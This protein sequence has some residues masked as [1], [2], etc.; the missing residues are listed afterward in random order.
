MKTKLFFFALLT[1]TLASCSGGG[2]G[3]GEPDDPGEQPPVNPTDKYCT[4][5]MPDVWVFNKDAS[6]TGFTLQTNLEA[7]DFN[8]TCSEAWCT[9]QVQPTAMENT[10]RLVV[11]ATEYDVRDANGIYVYDPPRTATM[12]IIG[13]GVFDRTITIVQNT[14]VIIST[15]LLPNTGFGDILHLSAAG[16][17]QEVTVSTNCY[18]WKAVTNA[19]WLTVSRK[20]N[21]TLVV[22]STARTGDTPRSGTVTIINESDELNDRHTFTVADKDAVLTGNDYQYGEGT[23]WD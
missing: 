1:A 22:T 13:S 6:S 7:S 20:D 2:G 15:P 11:N 19:A 18:S 5:D 14:N 23:D 21:V 4:T 3:A 9:A 16:E 17:T 10:K 12:R 8:V